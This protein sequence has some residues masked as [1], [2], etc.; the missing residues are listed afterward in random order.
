MQSLQPVVR[1]GREQ[2]VRQVVVLA[3]RE[4]READERPTRNVRVLV[5][6]PRPPLPCCTSCRRIMKNAND[7]NSGTTQ[8]SKKYSSRRRAA[9]ELGR[10]P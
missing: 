5:S 9:G 6:Q 7:V 2:V 4:D 3:H 1:H 10:R 8:S